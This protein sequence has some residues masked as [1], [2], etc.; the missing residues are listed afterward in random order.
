M[1]ETISGKVKRK[2]NEIIQIK[3]EFYKI[4]KEHYKYIDVD[5]NVTLTKSFFSWKIK[6]IQFKN[7]LKKYMIGVERIID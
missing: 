4:N 1:F 2:S 7:S 6:T 5:D 3:S